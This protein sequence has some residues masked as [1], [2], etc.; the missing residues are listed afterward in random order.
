[1]ARRQGTLSWEDV[2]LIY[3][4]A[5]MCPPCEFASLVILGR[6]RRGTRSTAMASCHVHY[7]LMKVE[8]GRGGHVSG[9]SLGLDAGACRRSGANQE[10]ASFFRTNSEAAMITSR[11]RTARRIEQIRRNLEVDALYGANFWYIFPSFLSIRGAN[12]FCFRHRSNGLSNYFDF[13]ANTYSRLMAIPNSFGKRGRT[14]KILCS[15]FIT[16]IC[17]RKILLCP[18]C[19]LPGQ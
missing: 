8:M 12:L 10:A 6:S 4:R 19:R 17:T 2:R 1:M 16:T 15:G 14:V 18:S 3:G 7:P 5:F 9:A 11:C 13:T